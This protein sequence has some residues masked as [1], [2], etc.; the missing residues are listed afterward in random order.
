MNETEKKLILLLDKFEKKE[1]DLES[2]IEFNK[3]TWPFFC[4]DNKEEISQKTIERVYN[5]FKENISLLKSYRTFEARISENYSKRNA[6]K[7]ARYMAL[8]AEDSETAEL[9]DLISK[10]LV[11]SC[12]RKYKKEIL[13]YRDKFKKTGNTKNLVNAYNI[14]M[15]FY[16]MA[17]EFGEKY[18]FSEK[19]CADII[20]YAGKYARKIAIEISRDNSLPEETKKEKRLLWLERWRK[21][22]KISSIAYEVVGSK[23]LALEERLS[24]AN[25]LSI[26]AKETGNDFYSMRANSEYMQI[27]SYQKEKEN[28]DLSDRIESVFSRAREKIEQ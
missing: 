2:I 7:A 23:V 28:T 20:S 27:L 18:G 14:S 22:K 26:I 25:A 1:K 13:K 16:S 15:R 11:E 10:A 3:S 8:V 6:A 19:V 9:W 21:N 17:L 24:G 4:K 12:K 5:A